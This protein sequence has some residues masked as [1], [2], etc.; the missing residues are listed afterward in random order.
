MLLLRSL[1]SCAGPIMHDEVRYSNLRVGIHI[2]VGGGMPL[3]RHDK[4]VIVHRYNNRFQLEH[5]GPHARVKHELLCICRTLA[6]NKVCFCAITSMQQVEFVKDRSRSSRCCYCK[7]SKAGP[8]MHDEVRYSN[9]H[10]GTRIHVG[11]GMPL[12][13]HDKDVIVHQYNNRFQLEHLGPHARVKHELLCICRTLAA[14]KVRFCAITSRVSLQC[15]RWKLLRNVLS[16]H[17]DSRR[18]SHNSC[19]VSALGSTPIESKQF[20]GDLFCTVACR[21]VRS[22]RLSSQTPRL[23]AIYDRESGQL[24]TG[25]LGRTRHNIIAAR[26]HG[27]KALLV[28]FGTSS[29][30]VCSM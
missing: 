4:D 23:R 3:S 9:L 29:T 11:G 24:G 8:I 7:V 27:A 26:F 16:R 25:W 10:V 2:H 14:N 21:S 6:A 15:S 13:R 12:S 20:R 17:F 5:L 30:R 19:W 22:A 28:V 1:K 18:A